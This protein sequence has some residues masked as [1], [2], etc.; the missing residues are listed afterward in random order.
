MATL[1]DL[2]HPIRCQPVCTFSPTDQVPRVT[3]EEGDSHGISFITSRLDNLRSNVG[4]HLDLPGHLLD[5][6]RAAW[7]TVGQMPL[8][9]FVGP[10]AVLDFSSKTEAIRDWFGPDGRFDRTR[11]PEFEQFMEAWQSLRITRTE[12]DRASEE[13]G[14]ALMDLAGVVLFTGLSPY[15]ATGG[16][17]SWEH[18]YFYAPFLDESAAWHIVDCGHT[19]VGV[20]A[21]Q[22]E[23]PLAN[24]RGDELPV[25][26]CDPTVGGRG[27]R[28]HIR[29][30]VAAWS[31]R[32]VHHQLLSAGVVIYENLRVGP[33][34]IN[35]HGW[36]SGP[37]LNLQLPGL[38]DN[39]LARP[40]LI[41]GEGPITN[42][43]EVR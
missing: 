10:C 41:T 1:H 40:Y 24:L 13:A 21:F 39:A 20:D 35:R 28:R 5:T 33:E 15:W 12:L 14:V 17:E 25:V 2:S 27:L 31:K 22:L 43:T 32:S 7:P 18:A 36:F 26:V 34:L 42:P 9:R 3:F 23:N 19:F 11:L 29:E 16:H 38:N 30:A 37:P 8:Q 6:A 4:T